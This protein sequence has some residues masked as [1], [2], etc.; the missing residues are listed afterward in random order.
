MEENGKF[1][2]ID[3]FG[4]IYKHTLH[5]FD[6]AEIFEGELLGNQKILKIISIFQEKEKKD[7]SGDCLS[8]K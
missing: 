6:D 7:R 3:A 2:S 8:I 5:N 1:F 4:K